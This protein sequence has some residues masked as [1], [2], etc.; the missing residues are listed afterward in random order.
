M[1]DGRRRRLFCRFP[2]SFFLSLSLSFAG[3][4]SRL[5]RFCICVCVCLPRV[6]S[7]ME[8]CWFNTV[9][10]I[11]DVSQ[12]EGASDCGTPAITFFFR[13]FFS[14][15]Y[16]SPA[17][18]NPRIVESRELTGLESSSTFAGIEFLT[19]RRISVEGSKFGW[20]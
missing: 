18:R 4:L 10:A 8:N 9:Y 14:L 12:R 2:Y 20:N 13:S 17:P 6:V 7:R 19:A 5:H 11:V 3:L 15:S 16:P 1:N